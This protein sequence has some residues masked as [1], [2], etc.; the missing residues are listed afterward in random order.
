[1]DASHYG[2]TAYHGLEE[3]G[4][5]PPVAKGAPA[6][7]TSSASSDAEELEKLRGEVAELAAKVDA[8]SGTAAV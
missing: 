2:G 3:A 4:L 8:L 6:K 1:V 7:D 5:A